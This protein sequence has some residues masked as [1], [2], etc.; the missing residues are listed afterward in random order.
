MSGARVAT[1]EWI[2][3]FDY[4]PTRRGAIFIHTGDTIT[5]VNREREKGPDVKEEWVSGTNQNTQ[6]HGIFPAAVIRQ[7]NVDEIKFGVGL[8]T[9][10]MKMIFELSDAIS[11]GDMWA[12]NKNIMIGDKMYAANEEVLSS[13]GFDRDHDGS[14]LVI[15]NKGERFKIS[16]NDIERVTSR[17][18]TRLY[19]SAF[20]QQQ[21]QQ[22][23]VF[24]EPI[25]VTPPSA[26]MNPVK[27]TTIQVGCSKDPAT[28]LIPPAWVVFSTK[29]NEQ[30]V[31][32]GHTGTNVN[33]VPIGTT[34][35]TGNNKILGVSIGGICDPA[36]AGK[37][38]E[39]AGRY[40]VAVEGKVVVTLK[41]DGDPLNAGDTVYIV[42][43]E[44]S[45]YYRPFFEQTPELFLPK[46]S[47]D[48]T[49]NL[50][51]GMITWVSPNHTRKP[52]AVAE[53]EV[54]LQIY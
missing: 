10:M 18:L 51:L 6:Y 47:L 43:D 24:T 38:P 23:F 46:V 8:T 52:N 2:A 53:V 20:E 54:L 31:V 7:K 1:S 3:K 11:K 13:V 49:K 15:N 12:A 19:S 42:P 39:S 21:Q 26:P 28:Q 41:S 27:G 17:D 37:F 9:E 22:Q 50:R 32:V 5:G 4:N 40:A 14:Y 44:T 45:R 36:A 16:P 29:V 35:L 33:R 30:G 48:P 25:M 34:E